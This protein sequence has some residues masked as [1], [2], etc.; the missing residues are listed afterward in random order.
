MG[1][2]HGTYVGAGKCGADTITT[3][4]GAMWVHS[5]KLLVPMLSNCIY[6]Y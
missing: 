6:G 5:E 1:K 4:E 2:L 3:T